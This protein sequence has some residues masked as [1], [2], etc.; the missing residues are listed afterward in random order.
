MIEFRNVYKSY[1]MKTE[2]KTILQNFNFTFHKGKN[3]AILGRNGVGKSTLIKMI[4]G[5]ETCDQGTIYRSTSVS[6]PLGFSKGFSGGMTGIENIKFVARVYGR[7]TEEIIEY[8]KEFS[9]LDE[10]IYLPIRTY[11]RGMKARLT[12]GL[13]MAIN[14]DCYLIDEIIS[15]GDRRFKQKSKAV[16][17]EKLAKST[18]IMVSHSMSIIRSYCDCGLLMTENGILYFDDVEDLIAGYKLYA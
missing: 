13:S 10:F 2:R 12:F 3:I 9:E 16:F 17:N 18:V 4:A 15:V 1:K 7:D 8:V 14:F 5:T 11:S 6:W